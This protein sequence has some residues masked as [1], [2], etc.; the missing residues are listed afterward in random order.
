MKSPTF[1][2]DGALACQAEMKAAL[3]GGF[4]AGWYWKPIFSSR[5]SDRTWELAVDDQTSVLG[6]WLLIR[7][8]S[9][10]DGC[11]LQNG[12]MTGGS[13][14]LRRM[15][16]SKRAGC[17]VLSGPEAPW[18]TMDDGRRMMDDGLRMKR[19]VI[20]SDWGTSDFEE[21][22][23]AGE[24]MVRG[25][26]SVFRAKRR[27]YCC[28]CYFARSWDVVVGFNR[29]QARHGSQPCLDQVGHLDST[30]KLRIQAP[31]A[32]AASCP[33]SKEAMVENGDMVGDSLSGGIMM[34]PWLIM[35]HGAA[36]RLLTCGVEMPMVISASRA[37]GRIE[38]RWWGKVS[39]L[40]RMKTSVWRCWGSLSRSGAGLDG[41]EL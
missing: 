2:R 40:G 6:Q 41:V 10:H 32:R 8:V 23:E 37:G 24:L 18:W 34:K 30:D 26:S 38:R 7:R 31:G 12:N 3:S 39:D 20:R 14:E 5:I 22:Y 1:H 28:G 13:M 21:C 4:S 36:R 11:V 16:Y 9:Q 15:Q 33:F 17:T 35:I 19:M 27:V 29:R 25:W